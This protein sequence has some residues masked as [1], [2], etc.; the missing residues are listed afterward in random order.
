MVGATS[1]PK[2]LK[3]EGELIMTSL[4]WRQDGKYICLASNPAGNVS[5]AANL[6]IRREYFL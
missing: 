3:S 2:V 4:T 6:S 5:S 1:T